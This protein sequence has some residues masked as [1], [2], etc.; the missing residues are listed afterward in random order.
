MMK[1]ISNN[2]WYICVF[3]LCHVGVNKNFKK[4]TKDGNLCTYIIHF[5]IKLDKKLKIGITIP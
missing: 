3:V 1:Y 2:I 4:I 5:L